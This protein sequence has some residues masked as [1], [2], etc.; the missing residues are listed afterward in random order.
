MKTNPD[1][2]MPEEDRAQSLVRQTLRPTM[3]GTLYTQNSHI[4]SAV[5]KLNICDPQ[6]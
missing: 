4:D 6:V 5:L 1:E 2:E 3:A